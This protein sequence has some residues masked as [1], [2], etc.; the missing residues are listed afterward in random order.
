MPARHVVG[1]EVLAEIADGLRGLQQRLGLRTEF[2]ADVTAQA[3]RIAAE[4]M[5]F[6]EHADLTD[7]GFVTVDPPGSMDLDQA[8]H[9]ERDGHGYRVR[10]AIADVAAWVEPGSPIDREAH[11]RGQTMYAPGARLPLH[12]AALSEGA[13]SLLADRRP[14]P[15]LVWTH[16]LDADGHVGSTTLQRALVTNR[17]QLSYQQVQA[18]V[19]AGR[20]PE[21]LALLR[22]VGELRRQIEIERGGISL[23][24]PDQ[25]IVATSHGWRTRFRSVV[26]AED[27]NAQIS[28]MTGIAAAEL[29]VAGKVGIIRTLP[30]AE[31]SAIDRLRRAARSLGVDW[32]SGVSYPD[33]VR[34]LDPARPAQLA[35]LA[36][37]T[38]LFRGAGYQ[39]FDAEM[40]PGSLIHSALASRYAHTTAPLRRL[41]DRYVLEI[42]HSLANSLQVPAWARRALPE[43]PQEMA[44]SGRAANGY[45]RGVVDLAEC[46]VLAGRV[47][48]TF[49]A[50]LIDVNPK[51][52]LGTFQ[53]AEPAVEAR[54]PADRR[55]L[56][57]VIRVRL[58][59]VDTHAGQLH[60]S[61]AT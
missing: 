21:T 56:G 54:M 46:L 12:P 50:V 57:S 35:V 16:R 40:P 3:E 11:R 49:E 19:D 5:S 26:P 13:A 10:Y 42:C 60:F 34:G 7:V 4:P 39:A 9:I 59:Q 30:A 47:G 38:L 8:L 36:K 27:W 25:E 52:G 61:S 2:P 53:I 29:M 43:L 17:A 45:E 58:D 48:E 37:C 24:L 15:A 44:E 55:D 41:V 18:D 33:F 20:A 1:S 23:N 22:R 31:D 32:P 51:T 28:L 6:P 14:R